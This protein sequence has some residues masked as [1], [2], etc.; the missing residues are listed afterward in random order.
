ML[1]PA[2]DVKN[3]HDAL[4]GEFDNFYEVQQEKVY[5]TQCEKAYI[6]ESEG[7]MGAKSYAMVHEIAF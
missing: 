4:A 3:L 1:H 2:G 7:P 6:A 5:F